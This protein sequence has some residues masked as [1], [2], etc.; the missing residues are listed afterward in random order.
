VVVGAKIFSRKL[1]MEKI[2]ELYG[3]SYWHLVGERIF[4]LSVF[5]RKI[6]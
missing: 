4:L 2:I 6:I 3:Y 1:S 5:K